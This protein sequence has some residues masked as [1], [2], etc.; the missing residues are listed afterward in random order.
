MDEWL[1]ELVTLAKFEEE[2][3]ETMWP[4][5]I[6]PRTDALFLGP[7]KASPFR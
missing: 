1:S 5:R 6:Q 2:M 3:I 4:G 7:L